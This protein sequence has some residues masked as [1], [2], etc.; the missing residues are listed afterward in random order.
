MNVFIFPTDDRLGQLSLIDHYSRLGHNVFLPAKGTLSLDWSK[1]ATWPA[2]LCNDFS[3]RR[4]LEVKNFDVNDPSVFGEDLF[5]TLEQIPITNHGLKCEII[6]LEK[7]NIQIDIF[8]T[9]RGGESF[10]R[11]YLNISKKFFPKAKWVSS[12][13]NAHDHNPAG[14]SPENLAGFI[15]AP[16]ENMSK[17]MRLFST[18]AALKVFGISRQDPEIQRSKEFAS[19]NHNFHIR[20]PE[21]FQI[22]T[23]INELLR[24]NN[25]PEVK[26]YGGNIRRMGAD[27][28]YNSG[29]PTGN[30]ETLSPINALKKISCLS[31][32]LH[33]KNTD[34]GGGV[35]YDSLQTD[36]PII[37]TRRYVKNSNS[38]KYL[39]DGVNC[40]H[41]DTPEEAF[42]AIVK[43]TE[44][45]N[46]SRS[47]REGMK[48]V[49]EAIFKNYWDDWERF[50]NSL[51]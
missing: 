11:E 45:D 30:F 46:F 27:L 2:L 9:L 48:S 28:R 26:N 1:I 6:D 43:I 16:Y 21:D 50:L 18:D 49:R 47:L 34:W 33:L 51:V 8:H 17:K 4:N 5:L 14:L 3:G 10:L 38:S 13:L 39:I 22:Y 19:F 31:G 23:K 7:E 37:T 35:F 24:K 42:K 15:P 29:G 40:I 41:I 12:T 36:T 44:D 25:T 32:V 20:Q